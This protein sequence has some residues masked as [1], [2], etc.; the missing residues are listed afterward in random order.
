VKVYAAT[1]RPWQ[2]EYFMLAGSWLACR[3]A[4]LDHPDPLPDGSVYCPAGLM[5]GE[6]ACGVEMRLVL[7]EA[8]MLVRQRLARCASRLLIPSA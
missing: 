1:G 4:A 7:K 3:L 5:V 6:L 8:G 2:R